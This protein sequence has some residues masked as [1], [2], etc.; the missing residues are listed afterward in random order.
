[1]KLNDLITE[2]DDGS[3]VITVA[4]S[5]IKSMLTDHPDLAETMLF[6]IVRDEVRRRR[7]STVRKAEDKAFSGY[8]SDP[9]TALRELQG[10]RFW[11]PLSCGLVAWADATA[12]QHIARADYIRDKI[13]ALALDAERHET[14]ADIITDAKVSCLA[15]LEIF[16]AGQVRRGTQDQPARPEQ[17][18]PA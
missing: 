1:M 14:A 16:R 2:A 7:R 3:D 5:V 18:D 4:R 9:L 13:R 12:E 8:D 10:E 15:D 17:P 11:D 6:P